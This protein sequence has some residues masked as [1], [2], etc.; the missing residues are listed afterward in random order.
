MYYIKVNDTILPTPYR[1]FNDALADIPR[2]KEIY[3]PCCADIV[4]ISQS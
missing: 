1:W 4:F 3:G 2:I